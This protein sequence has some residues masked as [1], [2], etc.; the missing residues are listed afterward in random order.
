MIW[1]GQMFSASEFSK[2]SE[3]E[4]VV[5]I[6]K[7]LE[8]FRLGN[9]DGCCCSHF[10]IRNVEVKI[11]CGKGAEQS[12]RVTIGQSWMRSFAK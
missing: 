2:M 4:K 6:I 3:P 11:S 12:V 9:W 5:A 10:S 1:C 8:C 7:E